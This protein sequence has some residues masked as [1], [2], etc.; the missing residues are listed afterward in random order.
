VLTIVTGDLLSS[1]IKQ[2]CEPGMST[3]IALHATH[4]MQTL[5]G[6]LHDH[7]I[8]QN[9]IVHSLGDGE[10][11]LAQVNLEHLRMG[12]A[13][14]I[15]GPKGGLTI[16]KSLSV[17]APIHRRSAVAEFLT[18]INWSL[19]RGLL[20]MDFS[21]GEIRVRYENGKQKGTVDL[22]DAETGLRLCC[23]MVD[24]FFPALMSV[25]YRDTQPEEALVQAE[26]Y[27]DSLTKE[28]E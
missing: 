18:H 16:E 11:L 24:S 15:N 14:C 7:L 12:V 13:F 22:N 9:L 27:H 6:P 26:K 3:A 23:R 8:Q 5:L 10:G 4:P 28:C 21:D 19:K 2:G 17:P 20:L 25:I 1:Q